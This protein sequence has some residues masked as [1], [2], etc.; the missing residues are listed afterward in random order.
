[1][2]RFLSLFLI[3]C[4]AYISPLS[5]QK[6][7]CDDN[8]NQGNAAFKA[9]NYDLAI[10]LFNQGNDCSSNCTHNFYALIVQVEEAER[11]AGIFILRANGSVRLDGPPPTNI[12]IYETP[13]IPKLNTPQASKA[14]VEPQMVKVAGGTFQMGDDDFSSSRPIHTVIVNNFSMGKY[15]VTQSEWRTV[16]GKDPEEL[17]EFKGDSMPVHSVSWEDIQEFLQKLNAKTGKI[18]RLPTE[19]EWEFAA[20]DRTDTFFHYGYKYSGSSDVGIV[21]W[22]N[23]TSESKVHAV[24][25]KNANGLG[26]YDMSGNV[27]E[28]CQD[29]SKGYLGSNEVRD[30]TGS[31]RV[32]RGGGWNSGAPWCR[33]SFRNSCNF[34]V[35][36]NSVGFRL[37]LSSL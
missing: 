23:E 4:L 37:A 33:C 8:F 1:M 9:K 15:E 10:R 29:W 11:A 26:I 24:G 21:A 17:T 13:S 12:D 19:E 5:A 31:D 16:M 2:A 7:C 18:Y 36:I 32:I 20:R 34:S 6:G 14:F 25:G 35:R 22:M 28:W 27:W 30:D 3:S